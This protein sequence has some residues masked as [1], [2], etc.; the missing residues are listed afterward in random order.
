MY[1]DVRLIARARKKKINSTTCLL[2]SQPLSSLHPGPAPT[3]ARRI[4][5]ARGCNASAVSPNE[6]EGGAPSPTLSLSQQ[7]Q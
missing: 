7:E 5:A 4:A 1:V 3:F 2:K 6:K